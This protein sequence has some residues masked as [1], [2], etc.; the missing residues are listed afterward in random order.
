MYNECVICPK[1]G[2]SCDGPNF[3]AMSAQELLSWCKQRKKHLDL[4]NADLAE[5]SGIPKGTV[6][7]LLAGEHLDFRYETVRP[8]IRAL[9][10][11]EWSGSPCPEPQAIDNTELI[12]K[13]ERLTRNNKLLQE[14]ID[15]D[16]AQHQQQLEF[17]REQIR[18]EQATSDGYKRTVIGLSI[19]LGISLLVIIAALIVDRLNNDIGFFWLERAFVSWKTMV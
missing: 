5:Q 9:V 12:E 18:H 16:N 13:V 2:L 7:R 11:S 3:V 15:R 8:L 4:S 6:D 14:H 10:G 17:L 1:L 19:T